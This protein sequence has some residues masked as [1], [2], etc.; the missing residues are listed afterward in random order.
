[1]EPKWGLESIFIAIENDV[2]KV[3]RNLEGEG[4]LEARSSPV[5]SQVGA[6]TKR[7]FF[8]TCRQGCSE[9]SS[10]NRGSPFT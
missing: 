5:R 7:Q 8:T 3:M 10:R 1:M 4:V 6:S 2:K 9:S